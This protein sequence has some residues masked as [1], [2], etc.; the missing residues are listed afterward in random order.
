MEEFTAQI[1][2]IFL[3]SLRI[4][5]TFAFAPP[6][7]LL[8]IP[9]I[10]RVL[11]GLSLAAWLVLANPEQTYL[12]D[13]TYD[14][15]ALIAF[16]EIIIGTTLML[17]LQWMSA[18][19]LMIGRSIDIQTGFGL[20]LLI[21]PTTRSQR[22]L[23]GTIFAYAAGAVFF[24]LE[25]PMDLLA[26]WAESIRQ[27]PLGSPLIEPNIPLLLSFI[28]TVFVIATGLAG[29]IL[30][31]LFLIDLTVAFLSRTLPQMNVLLIGFQVKT[32]AV[33]ATLPLAIAYSTSAYIR[34]VR[35]SI[36]TIPELAW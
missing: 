21:D 8:R 2:A 17:T 11:L 34:L 19:I 36:E 33:L 4:A 28:S 23:I 12:R 24:S 20:A 35:V 26:I 9:A 22:P 13:I 30:L 5:P 32:L 1:I 15:L 25:A 10:I 6:F 18:A 29:I 27:I 31:T 7:T 3:I 14:N 16:G